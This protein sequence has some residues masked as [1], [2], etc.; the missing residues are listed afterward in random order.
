AIDLDVVGEAGR[1]SALQRLDHLGILERAVE[2]EVYRDFALRRDGSEVLD[3]RTRR[4]GRGA[5]SEKKRDD[6]RRNAHVWLFYHILWS[7]GR[8]RPPISRERPAAEGGRR[9]TSSPR[10]GGLKPTAPREA[11]PAQPRPSESSPRTAS[12]VRGRLRT[13]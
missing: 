12:G 2:R 9:S 11:V 10:S 6:S 8:P 5:K 1:Q 3:R 13:R 7:G 4:R